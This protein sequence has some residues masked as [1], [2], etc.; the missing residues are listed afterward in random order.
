M[1]IAFFK[2]KLQFL[3][4]SKNSDDLEQVAETLNSL[5]MLSCCAGLCLEAIDYYN[6]AL[7]IQMKLGCDDVQLAMAQ[8]LA[9]SVQYSLGHFKKALKLFEDAILTLH[10]EVDHEQET[11]AATLH[12]MGVV[13]VTLC[14]FD[15]AMSDLCN[16]LK[17]RRSCLAMNTQPHFKREGRSTISTQ[18]AS[19]KS[20]WH[21]KKT[22]KSLRRKNGFMQKET[23]RLPQLSQ[24]RLRPSLKGGQRCCTENPGGLY[25][26]WLEF[27]NMDHP[28]Q[29]TSFTSLQRYS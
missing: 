27:L 12:H 5:G 7:G 8:V 16:A 19:L 1:A 24:H 13:C 2:K 25:N 4:D 17:I 3:N 20:S 28:L 26:V 22:M 6:R 18:Y 9:G 14:N 15:D 23:Q 21:F 11:L 10:D 29:A